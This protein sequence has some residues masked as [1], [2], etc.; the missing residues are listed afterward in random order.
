MAFVAIPLFTPEGAY[1]ELGRKLIEQVARTPQISE[2]VDPEQRRELV[3]LLTTNRGL[4]GKR[5]N[6]NCESPLTCWSQR[7]I[8]KMAGP[9][10]L[11][12]RPVSSGTLPSASALRSKPAQKFPPTPAGTATLSAES[13][14]KLRKA[15]RSPAVAPSTALR[16]SVQGDNQDGAAALDVNRHGYSLPA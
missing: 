13:T 7:Q 11:R 6:L 16:C 15:E 10:G 9:T 5:S 2:R 3:G 1:M 14:S 12:V 4:R 8:V